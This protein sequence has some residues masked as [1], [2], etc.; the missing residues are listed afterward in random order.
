MHAS[1]RGRSPSNSG[2]HQRREL[3]PSGPWI[4]PLLLGSS[5]FDRAL[6]EPPAS[7]PRFHPEEC[8]RRPSERAF[9][10][11]SVPRPRLSPHCELP[12]L[13]P[14]R[15]GQEEPGLRQEPA[16]PA[17]AEALFLR[18]QRSAHG[19]QAWRP[20]PALLGVPQRRTS[21]VTIRA[22]SLFANRRRLEITALQK[23]I[24]RTLY[25]S[26]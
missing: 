15:V 13:A 17:T 19:A 14:G 20:A 23:V 8:V 6:I 25:L 12:R 16:I 10:G 5:P 1:A 21:E 7:P 2:A 9:A 26:F 18:R 4:L 22:K 24:Y 11:T 3:I